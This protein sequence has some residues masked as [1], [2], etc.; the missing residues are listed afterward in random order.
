MLLSLSLGRTRVKE[1]F[2]LN[3]LWCLNID[4]L[5]HEFSFSVTCNPSKSCTR[6]NEDTT[7][8]NKL[9]FPT[10]FGRGHSQGIYRICYLQVLKDI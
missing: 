8:K 10:H 7:S 9:F 6:R 4:Q 3:A 5:P 2:S 1:T